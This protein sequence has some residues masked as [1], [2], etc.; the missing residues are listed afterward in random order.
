MRR[1]YCASCRKS[2]HFLRTLQVENIDGV[3]FRLFVC[4]ECSYRLHI[5]E[6]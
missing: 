2:Q 5:R 6:D 1:Y 4:E 3:L